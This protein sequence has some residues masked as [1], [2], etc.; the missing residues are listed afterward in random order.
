VPETAVIAT[1]LTRL[2]VAIDSVEDMYASVR[3]ALAFLRFDFWM[4]ALH[5]QDRQAASQ[6]DPDALP[7][8]C[9][10]PNCEPSC[11]SFEPESLISLVNQ[12]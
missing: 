8:E 5:F 9:L 11:G 4:H 6:P 3:R 7:V 12:S 2:C 1:I 10:S